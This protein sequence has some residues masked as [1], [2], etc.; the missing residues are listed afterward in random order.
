MT[1]TRYIS[2]NVMALKNRAE[3]ITPEEYDSLRLNSWE[4]EYLIDKYDDDVLC[5]IAQNTVSNATSKHR[6]SYRPCATY[7][8]FAIHVLLPEFSARLRSRTVGRGS[9]KIRLGCCDDPLI[10]MCR[11]VPIKCC[12]CGKEFDNQPEEVNV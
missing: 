2:E 3:K 10:A 9:F 8:E 5:R 11:N 6:G 4:R 12:N 1:D 7:D